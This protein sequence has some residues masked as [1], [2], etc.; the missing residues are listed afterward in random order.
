MHLKADYRQKHEQSQWFDLHGCLK[1]AKNWK[2]EAKSICVSDLYQSH[3]YN[4]ITE[5]LLYNNG[6]KNKNRNIWKQIVLK[7]VHVAFTEN[8]V[9]IGRGVDYIK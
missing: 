4:N 5:Y 9:I 7:I 1:I 3:F 2:E 6:Y 8:G